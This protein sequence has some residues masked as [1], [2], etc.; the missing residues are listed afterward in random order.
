ME[1][2]LVDSEEGTKW[3][4]FFV[5]HNQAIFFWFRRWRR[6]L[7]FFSNECYYWAKNAKSKYMPSAIQVI[8]S[9]SLKFL[10]GQ[11]KLL[12]YVHLKRWRALA[13]VFSLSL[14]AAFSASIRQSM[15]V[16]V[17]VLF[18]TVEAIWGECNGNVK[19]S[20]IG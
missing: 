1:M 16:W 18:L 7:V 20:W 13:A 11:L 12:N 17:I 5:S 15:M 4:A 19:I 9:V 14:K 6:L 3:E 8:T 10:D 2:I